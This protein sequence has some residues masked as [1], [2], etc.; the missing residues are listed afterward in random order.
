MAELSDAIVAI[1]NGAD[2]DVEYTFNGAEILTWESETVTQPT[3]EELQ[4]KL[5]ELNGQ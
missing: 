3:S 5:E 1:I 2:N 4:T